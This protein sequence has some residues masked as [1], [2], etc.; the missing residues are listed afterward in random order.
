M[1]L[2]T[3]DILLFDYKDGGPFGIFTKLIKYFTKST[4][5]HVA[6]STKR[7]YIHTSIT[8]RYIYIWESIGR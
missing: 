5:S 2:K 7:S 3:G 6:R 1:D 8:E 4:Y